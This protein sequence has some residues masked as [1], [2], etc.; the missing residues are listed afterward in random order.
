MNYPFTL[1]APV[2][3]INASMKSLGATL[4]AAR[5]EGGHSIR[6]QAGRAGLSPEAVERIE[7][8]AGAVSFG[9]VI[10]LCLS[11]G[12]RLQPQQ[13]ATSIRPGASTVPG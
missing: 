12:V 3:S 2:G 5:M 6:R 10:A 7:R 4:R 8:G 11:L 13:P 9:E 1:A